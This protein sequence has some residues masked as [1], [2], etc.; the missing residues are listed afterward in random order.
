MKDE[1]GIAQDFE[2]SVNPE[3]AS[4]LLR[5]AISGSDRP[6]DDLLC[7]LAESDS[8]AWLAEALTAGPVGAFGSPPRVLCEGTLTLDQLLSIKKD[9]TALALKARDQAARL[10]AMASYFFAV[11]AGLAH[12]GRNISSR[13][14]GHLEPM[15]L[16][17][18]AVTPEV[19]SKLFVHA[20]AAL[21]SEA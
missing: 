3:Q 11:A 2:S 21:S 6:V 13:E 8:A 19:W 17:L 18:A 5:L 16:D 20:A 1:P 10:A 14:R 7:R 12:F 4:R 9:S 15:L